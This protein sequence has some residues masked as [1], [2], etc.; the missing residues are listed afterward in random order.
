MLG[1]LARRV[2]LMSTA[3]LLVPRE[4]SSA[5]ASLKA[6]GSFELDEVVVEALLKIRNFEEF[7]FFF[8]DGASVEARLSKLSVWGA[9]V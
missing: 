2:T 5:E 9:A 3:L 6:L 8:I 4:G 7:R 1:G